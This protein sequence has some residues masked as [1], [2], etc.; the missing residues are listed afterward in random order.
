MYKMHAYCYRWSS[1][2]GVSVC[3]LVT[4]LGPTK[5]GWNFLDADYRVDSDGPK[6]HVLDG[7]RY[8]SRVGALMGFDLE[9]SHPQLPSTGSGAVMRCD[10][11]IDFG[12][13]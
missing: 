3:L 13:V 1:E 10:S 4:F 12:T 9:I 11:C 2:V 8:P 7:G 6:I 5:N